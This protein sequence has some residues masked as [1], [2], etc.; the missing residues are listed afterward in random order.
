MIITRTS[1]KSIR[2]RIIPLKNLINY[3]D[4]DIEVL[5]KILNDVISNNVYNT[6]DLLTLVKRNYNGNLINAINKI[7]DYSDVRFNCFYACKILKNKLDDLNIKSYLISYKSIG[8]SNEQGDNLIKEAHMSVI[9]PTKRNNKVY[10]ILMDPG[11]RIPECMCFYKDEDATEIKI[12][13]DIITIKK[14]DDEIYNYTMIM[15]GYNRYSVSDISYRCQEYFDLDHELINPEELLFPV[16]FS[17][18]LGYRAIRF[19]SDKNNQASIKMM[20]IDEYL[21]VIANQECKRLSFKELDNMTDA[22]LRRVLQQ[23]TKILNI[24][25]YEFMLLI[26]FILS[27]KD[28]IRDTVL[29]S[30]L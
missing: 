9:I 26:R 6:F 20:V 5:N 18:L 15:E 3:D 11:L 29:Y 30:I 25:D 21:E 8:F 17:V 13:E 1:F 12:D 16:V 10:Y 19:S 4:I 7:K 28:E 27:I 23:S 14:T 24:D 2:K 22:E